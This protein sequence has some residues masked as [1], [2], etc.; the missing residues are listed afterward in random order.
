MNYIG[1]SYKKIVSVFI[2]SFLVPVILIAAVFG[3]ADED[4]SGSSGNSN[5]SNLNAE[6][7]EFIMRMVAFNY[8]FKSEYDLLASVTTAQA[9]EESGWGTSNVYQN[10]FNLF[11]MKGN[12][13]AGNYKGYQKFNNEKECI[14]AYQKL[15][16]GKYKCKGI[17]DYEKVLVALTNGGYCEGTEYAGK[18]RNHIVTYDL[19]QFDNLSE[20][21]LQKVRDRTYGDGVITGQVANKGTTQERAR[22]L[23][24]DGVPSSA[25]QMKKYLT[26]ISVEI[27]DKNG[28]ATTAKLTCHKALAEEIQQIYREMKEIGFRAY[29]NGCYNW[30][31]ITGSSSKMSNHAF[32]LAIDINPDYN[33]YVKGTYSSTWQNAPKYY[34]IDNDIVNIWKKHGFFWG[35]DYNSIKDYMHFEYIDGAL[36]AGKK[37]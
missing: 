25:A 28:K 5:I 8:D 21:D 35:G 20:E 36:T 34:K 13:T 12:G 22:S 6:Q 3:F 26:T 16:S 7:Y 17:K 23:F 32:G 29:S 11:G 15:I 1:K 10:S 33:P 37:Y 31:N 24:P 19:T 18:I 9:I 27:L 4:D 14:E 30:R 2:I